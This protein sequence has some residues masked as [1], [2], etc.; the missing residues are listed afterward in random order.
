MCAFYSHHSLSFVF[1]AG[2]W[3]HCVRGRGNAVVQLHY[4]PAA[5][6]GKSVVVVCNLKPAKFA[7]VQSQGLIL[8]ACRSAV[9][10]ADGM[11]SAYFRLESIDVICPAFFQPVV[12]FSP[13]VF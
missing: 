1:G 9:A 3:F 5:L 10:A 2:G 6:I 8:T 11:F 4:A 7:G 12:S 13:R